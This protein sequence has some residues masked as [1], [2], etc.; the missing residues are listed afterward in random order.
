MSFSKPLRRIAAASAFL[1]FALPSYAQWTLDNAA[2][3]LRFVTT[4]NT[5]VAEVQQFKKLSGEVATTG[6]VRLD[7]DL[8]SVETLVP[9]RN[10][11]LQTLLFDV[12]QFPSARFE[13]QV[14]M[15]RVAALEPGASA[16]LDVD[17]K[18][19]IHGKTQD[20]KA[21]LRVV[22]LKGERLQ[23]STRAPI[24]VSTAQ[25][26]LV[27]GIETLRQLMGL[28]NIIGTVPVSFALTFQQK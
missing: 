2:S 10:E 5:N 3:D 23:V 13:G 6:A 16:D 7:I 17:G 1:L 21:L 12:A 20:T 27:A 24:L 4:K 15:Q 18:L 25:F 26:D 9:I 22:R 11:R 14:D 19:S 28:P 8:A